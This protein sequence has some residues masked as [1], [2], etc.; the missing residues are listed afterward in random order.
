MLLF[1][2]R[3]TSQSARVWQE[4]P[5]AHSCQLVASFLRM[6]WY[7]LSHATP[8]F[9]QGG[10]AS[11]SQMAHQPPGAGSCG[12]VHLLSYPSAKDH[13]SLGTDYLSL[14]TPALSRKTSDPGGCKVGRSMK[15]EQS[16]TDPKA[17]NC[18]RK[19]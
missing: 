11:I 4:L 2:L 14:H 1:W 5:K 15:G 13:A 8:S 17:Q 16:P 19:E 10:S 18:S 12:T 9:S 3:K 7:E 6:P